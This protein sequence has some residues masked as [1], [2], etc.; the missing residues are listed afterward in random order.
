ML[1]VLSFYATFRHPILEA[2][3]LTADMCKYNICFSNLL[4][5]F[6]FVRKYPCRATGYANGYDFCA[7]TLAYAIAKSG[8]GFVQHAYFLTNPNMLMNGQS[9]C[10]VVIFTHVCHV[11]YILK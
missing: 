7:N 1:S 4:A 10:P 9:I 5:Y 8:K 2:S 6:K 11:S 3:A